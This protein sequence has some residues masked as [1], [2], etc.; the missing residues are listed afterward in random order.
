MFSMMRC[1]R[2]QATACVNLKSEDMKPFAVG[3]MDAI[4]SKIVT[5]E[6]PRWSAY[7]FCLDCGWA[8]IDLDLL[9]PGFCR[10]SISAR[11]SATPHLNWPKL[12]RISFNL[13][14]VDRDVRKELWPNCCPHDHSTN[15]SAECMHYSI[16]MLPDK[17]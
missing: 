6:C 5:P 12:H 7:C 15:S 11:S 16:D 17:K 4:R 13:V 14:S 10:V 1:R 2:F 3:Q 8:S 9:R